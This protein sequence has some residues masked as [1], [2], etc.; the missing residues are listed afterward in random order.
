MSFRKAI[1]K[2]H[3]WL[4]FGSGLIVF[5]VSVTG[6][7]YA[8]QAEIQQMTQPYRYTTPQYK[9][10]LMPSVLRTIAENELP[11]KKV[12]AV[13]YARPGNSAQVI[14][15]DFEAGYYDLVYINPYTGKVLKVKNENVDFFRVVLMGHF[16]LW[17]PPEIGQP[18]VASATLIFLVMLVTGLVMWWPGNKGAAKQRFTIK[19]DARWRRRNYDLHNVLGFYVTWIAIMLAI[20][21][22]IF[23][24][25]WFARGIYNLAGGEKMLTYT[26]PSSDTTNISLSL[27]SVPASDRLYDRLRALYPN[28]EVMEVHVPESSLSPI[29]VSINADSKTYWKTDYRY[30]DQRTLEELPVDHIYGRIA[31]ATAADKLI[32]MNY[33]VHTGAIIGL[34]GKIL[35]FFASLLCASLPVT[36]FYIWWGRR[37]RSSITSTEHNLILR[38]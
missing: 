13:L 7:I 37:T 30:F 36:G 35:A 28:A 26:E 29:A 31:D 15:Y 21:G 5:I 34:P 14:F 3:L 10:F 32:R 22:L 33:D 20:T 11:G 38:S 6:C 1:G 17:L 16:Y 24:F 19:W 12:H 4:G 8:F 2:L 9:R 23:G 25:Q 18:V 27:S